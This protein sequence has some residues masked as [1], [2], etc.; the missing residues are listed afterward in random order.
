M[1]R[2]LCL[3]MILALMMSAIPALA[4]EELAKGS[5]GIDVVA[6]QTYLNLLGYDVGKADGDFG[7]KTEN[8]ILAYQQN[9]EVEA[10]GIADA[11]TWALLQTDINEL[12]TSRFVVNNGN[13]NRPL[14]GYVDRN[15]KEV[16]PCQYANATN[17]FDGLAYVETVDGIHGYIDING[18]MLFKTEGFSSVFSDGVARVFKHDGKQFYA[19]GYGFGRNKNVKT[20]YINMAGKECATYSNNFWFNLG[21]SEGLAIVEDNTTNKDMIINKHGTSYPINLD[22][23]RINNGTNCVF[24]EGRLPYSIKQNTFG[25]LNEQ[26]DVIIPF[27]YSEVRYFSEGLCAVK[28]EDNWGYINRDGDNIIPFV[29]E[30]ATSFY[31]GIAIVKFNGKWGTINTKGIYTEAPYQWDYLVNKGEGICEF[32]EGL[33][34]VKADGKYGF[35]N[36]KGELVIE[37]V[38]NDPD[39]SHTFGGSGFDTGHYQFRNGVCMVSKGEYDLYYIDREGHIITYAGI[40]ESNYSA[41]LTNLEYNKNQEKYSPEEM[42]AKAVQRIIASAKAPDSVQIYRIKYFPMGDNY[43]FLIDC[44]GDNSFG[45]TTRETVCYYVNPQTGG[46]TYDSFSSGGAGVYNG[47]AGTSVD[48]DIVMKLIK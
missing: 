37:C 36:T 15:G 38:W 23:Y 22:N 39:G 4:F 11:S 24:S 1:K 35:V 47:Y 5:K 20:I 16:I 3:I 8:A 42:A 27:E 19:N 17:F 29:Y 43:C 44:S 12:S 26:G 45:G 7:S 40:N 14:Y 21:F 34:A 9:K 48:V 46:A 10:T 25:F 31:D 30:E 13:P 32:N 41:Y 18:N 33:I 28:K 2:F 6:L